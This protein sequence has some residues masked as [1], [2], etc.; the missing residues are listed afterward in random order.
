MAKQ[1]VT[2]DFDDRFVRIVQEIADRFGKDRMDELHRL[3]KELADTLETLP[4]PGT[5]KR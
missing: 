3:L 2:L 4:P 1:T 5:P